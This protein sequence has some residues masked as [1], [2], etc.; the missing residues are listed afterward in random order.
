ME[1]GAIVWD[2]YIT[3]NINKLE[4][5]QRQ[6]A[7]FITGD[8]RSR[9]D[10]CITNMLAKLELQDLKTRR[11]SQKLIFLY[12]VVEGLVPAIE[13][14]DFLKKSRPKRKI[15]TKKFDNFETTNII[16]KQVKNNTKCF[17]IPP[18]KTPQ[19]TNFFF[20]KTIIDWNHLEDTIVRAPSVESFKTALIHRQ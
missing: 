1:Y 2:P 5:V 15:S 11:S 8:Y 14:E 20:V 16:E 18:S 13:P 4:R 12:K 19:Y 6:A 9:E 7:R 17:N 3:S 10:G